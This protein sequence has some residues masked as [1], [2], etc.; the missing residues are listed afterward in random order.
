MFR[1]VMRPTENLAAQQ[2]TRREWVRKTLNWVVF[3]WAVLGV[4]CLS[5]YCYGQKDGLVARWSFE[6]GSGQ[7]IHDSVR[8]IDDKITGV[9]RHVAGV[10]GQA[11]RFNTGD[12]PENSGN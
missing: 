5:D 4:L 3:G 12:V 1:F 2:S 6:E 7:V 11:L 8:G 10:E 9:F